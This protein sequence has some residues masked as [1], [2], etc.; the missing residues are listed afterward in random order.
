MARLAPDDDIDEAVA[1]AMWFPGYPDLL[2]EFR[3]GG[4][5]GQPGIP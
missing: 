4:S 1:A 2:S 3:A 5:P